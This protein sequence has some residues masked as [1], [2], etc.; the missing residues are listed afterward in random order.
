MIGGPFAA[1]G[2]LFGYAGVGLLCGMLVSYAVMHVL[3]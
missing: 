3:L 2:T 1:I